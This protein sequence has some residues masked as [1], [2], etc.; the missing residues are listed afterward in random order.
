LYLHCNILGQSFGCCFFNFCST[1]FAFIRYLG[2][3]ESLGAESPSAGGHWRSW[4]EGKRWAI[5]VL[6]IMH[7]YAHFGQM[8]FYSNNSSIKII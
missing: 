2:F 7:F 8:L 5:F 3:A 6:K 1:I 4:S